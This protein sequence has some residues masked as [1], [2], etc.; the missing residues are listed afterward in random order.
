V[1]SMKT[2]IGRPVRAA[3]VGTGFI[4]EFHARALKAIP[5]VELVGVCDANPRTAQSFA[6]QW[7]ISKAFQSCEEMLTQC[8]MDTVHVL[9]APDLHYAITKTILRSSK[10]VFIEKP[11][12]TSA[13]EANELLDIARIQGVRIGVNHNALFSGGYLNLRQAV[14]SGALGTL[15]HLTINHFCELKPIRFGPFDSWMF[16]EP[17]NAFLEIGPHLISIAIDLLGMLEVHSVTADRSVVLPTGV[18][19][20]RRWRVQANVGR[21]AVDINIDLG[22]GFTQRT[23]CVR[24]V[25][26][27][28]T[29]DLDANTC[30]IDG[31]TPFGIDIDRYRRSMS[32]ARQTQWQARKAFANYIL[33][34]IKM[35]RGGSPFQSSIVGSIAAF[36]S[37]LRSGDALDS[38]ISGES[39][40]A[41]IKCCTAII[42]RA[43]LEAPVASYSQRGGA[44][45][46]Q[47]TVLVIGGSGFIGRELVRQLLG[48]GYGVRAM[49]RKS[50]AAMGQFDRERLEIFQGDLR[51]EADLT[52]AM[53]GI[54][55][56]YDLAVS[57][58]KTWD[59]S[60]RNIVEPTRLLAKTCLTSGVKRYIYTGTID[61]Y[62]A[63]ERAGTITEET[64]LDPNI[65]RRNYYARAK[66]ASEALLMDMH[67]TQGLP[68]V[69][70]RPGIV[71]GPA[72]NPFHWGVGRFSETVCEV[73]G[74]GT[75]KLPFVLVGDVGAAL[76]RGIQVE[77]IEGRSYNLIDTPLLSARDYLQELERLAGVK[78]TVFYRPIWRFYIN[79]LAKWLVKSATGHPDRHRVPSYRD[80]ESRT[81][82]AVFDCTRARAELG[83]APASDRKRMIDEGIGGSLQPWLDAVR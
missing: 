36:Y 57:E 67:R 37:S 47:P 44:P 75:N 76:L 68:V 54:E 59:A 49:M 1:G 66:A 78:L 24:G 77:S 31:S 10:A 28:A 11:I 43:G 42:D 72:G 61:S 8:D 51:N 70:F 6:S 60:M 7:H 22:P 32:L 34:K 48:T 53:Q 30:I 16:R 3:M 73:W 82:R 79:D 21:T 74:S 64:P 52:A 33:S 62:Y 4:A 15:E 14:H 17:Q 35:A 12:C 40:S 46:V 13:D 50:A 29:L 80:W 25:T 55:F 69:I 41:V 5:D 18:A 65:D 58:Q 23:C 81:Q 63:G 27:S 39:G 19:V 38:R 20:Y 9:T 71:I 45:A 56:V 2:R 26:G 83:W